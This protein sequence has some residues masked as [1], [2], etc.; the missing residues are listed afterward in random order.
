MR[1][2]TLRIDI[3]SRPDEDELLAEITTQ[4]AYVGDVRQRDGE[5]FLHLS[6]EIPLPVPVDDLER[7]IADIRCGLATSTIRTAAELRDALLDQ[8]RR[9]ERLSVPLGLWLS[10]LR[11]HPE[12]GFAMADRSEAP[13]SVLAAVAVASDARTRS[14]LA[15]RSNAEPE[16]L[17]FLAADPDEAVVGHVVA[18]PATPP[19][20]VKALADH[21][22]PKVS[23]RARTRLPDPNPS[24]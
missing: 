17:R 21:P 1:N 19:D 24:T 8:Q 10:C 9:S 15:M 18:H 13:R 12:T 3:T 4:E 20:V 5:L 22:W 7:A 23:E 2:E 6:A 16:L 14:R 11:D